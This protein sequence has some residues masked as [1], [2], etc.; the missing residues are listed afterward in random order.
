MPISPL[1]F[2]LFQKFW[3]HYD[4]IHRIEEFARVKRCGDN[5]EMLAYCGAKK[6]WSLDVRTIG[7]ID[8]C[9]PFRIIRR[10]FALI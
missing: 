6:C 4:K 3:H 1:F 10:M 8:V 9:Y 5:W 7:S 2:L